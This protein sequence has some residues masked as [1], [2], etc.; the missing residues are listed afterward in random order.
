MKVWSVPEWGG[1]V[2]DTRRLS[3][4][5][6]AGIVLHHTASAPRTPAAT[7]AAERAAAFALARAIQKDHR[8]R[9]RWMDSG[10]HFTISRGGVVLEGR[11]GSL[12]AARKG[13]VVA[14]AHAGNAAINGTHWGLEV[15]GNSS[16]APPTPEQLRAL[17]ELCAH[18]SL[19]GR[20]QAADL[21]PHQQYRATE[22]PGAWLMAR[23]PSLRLA[24]KERKLELMLLK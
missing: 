12:E 17:V 23:L 14:G 18:L 19:W 5:P 15:E 10:Q 1:T 8:T 22:C 4:K 6:A 16:L 13:L 21:F 24:V 20:T 9:N 2:V 7:E 3:R 11:T